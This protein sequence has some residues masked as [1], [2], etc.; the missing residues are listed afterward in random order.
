MFHVRRYRDRKA[1]RRFCV[2]MGKPS[3]G[4]ESP[5][6]R[7]EPLRDRTKEKHT[8]RKAL[9]YGLTLT[10]ALMLTACGQPGEDHGVGRNTRTVRGN[11]HSSS[12]DGHTAGR[13]HYAKADPGGPGETKSTQ[14]MR[15][16]KPV[17]TV[18]PAAQTT[19]PS[20]T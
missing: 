17:S 12:G 7:A 6:P 10:F 18:K 8:V 3:W 9:I 2:L 20:T 13:G 11:A 1:L 16:T 19:K 4:R 5:T 14:P 15:E